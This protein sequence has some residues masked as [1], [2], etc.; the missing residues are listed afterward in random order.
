LALA[1]YAE[2][3]SGDLLPVHIHPLQILR[4]RKLKSKVILSLNP[5]PEGGTSFAELVT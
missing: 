1:V 3:G 4:Q 2:R 5:S